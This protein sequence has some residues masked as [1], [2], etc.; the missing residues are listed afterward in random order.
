MALEQVIA[1]ERLATRTVERLLF[2]VWERRTISLS[3]GVL[4]YQLTYVCGRA[5]EDVQGERT[6]FHN[7]DSPRSSKRCGVSA[8]CSGTSRTN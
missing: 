1:R 8:P 4:Y 3:A 5:A 2:G 7:A 6:T